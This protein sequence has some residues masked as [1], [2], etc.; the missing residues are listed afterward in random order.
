M[1]APVNSTLCS[2]AEARGQGLSNLAW[3][4]STA[5]VSCG[6]L[7]C[8]TTLTFTRSRLDKYWVQ[9][10]EQLARFETCCFNRFPTPVQRR[11]PLREELKIL[12]PKRSTGPFQSA[13]EGPC[14]SEWPAILIKSH[15]MPP[16][17]D[18]AVPGSTLPVASPWCVS[19]TCPCVPDPDAKLPGLVDLEAARPVPHAIQGPDLQ[20]VL[21]LRVVPV[22]RLPHP[23][24]Q[25]LPATGRNTRQL[26][27]EA[28]DITRSEPIAGTPAGDRISE[29]V[30]TQ[31]SFIPCGIFSGTSA[32]A[33]GLL[34][35]RFLPKSEKLGQS[36][37]L[38]LNLE[39]SSM[40]VNAFTAPL[41]KFHSFAADHSR[42]W[43]FWLGSP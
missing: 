40:N 18:M 8:A 33:K 39:A 41:S 42:N 19:P 2:S 23:V 24:R 17:N 15:D 1:K 27:T 9:M 38:Y 7:V 31:R 36:L 28:L 14:L 32:G 11:T 29:K 16:A 13:R 37:L 26:L 20:P 22:V 12:K 10:D 35:F 4:S 3:F 43:C 21:H 34:P 5:S 6:V 30:R 25:R